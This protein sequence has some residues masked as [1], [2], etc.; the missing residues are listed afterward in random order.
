MSLNSWNKFFKN[1]IIFQIKAGE[2]KSQVDEPLASNVFLNP[3]EG[4]E[5]P[6]LSPTNKHSAEKLISFS[7]FGAGVVRGIIFSAVE[8]PC[9]KNQCV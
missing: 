6:S 4:N 1:I 7:L 8:P 9:G 2:Q 5:D 3:P